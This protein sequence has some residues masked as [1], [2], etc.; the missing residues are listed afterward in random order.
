[1]LG[2]FGQ[3]SVEGQEAVVRQR[4]GGE[5]GVQILPSPA[6][7]AL[8]PALAARAP[9]Q[10]PAHRLGGGGEE[11]SSVG[12]VRIPD[13]PQIRVVDQGGGVERLPRLLAGQLRR[14]Q[15]AQLVVDQRQQ[16]L[17]GVRVALLD[18]GK[19]PGDLAHVGQFIPRK[20]ARLAWRAIEADRALQE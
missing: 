10:D 19:D 16:L 5:V 20:P 4:C 18:S 15:P 2:E 7:A 1:V 6:P 17:R 3:G 8:D 14:G 9:D 11:M 13:Q 12:E